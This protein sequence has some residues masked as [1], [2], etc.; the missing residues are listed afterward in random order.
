M[1]KTIDKGAVFY[2]NGTWNFIAKVV[3]HT[4]YTIE[5]EKRTGFSSIEEAEQ[6]Q[7]QENDRYKKHIARVKS[8]TNMRY[9]FFEYLDYWYQNIYLPNSDSSIKICYSWT[10]YKIIFPKARRDVLIGM[11][12]SDYLNEILDSCK[13][14]CESAGPMINKLFSVAL[15]D[16]MDDDYL[17]HNPLTDMKKYYWN[18]PKMVIYSKDQIRTL[19]QAAYEY[20]SI[21]LE[22]LLALFAGLRKGEIA[23]L[24]YSDFDPEKQTVRIERQITR[25]YQVVVKNNLSYK[26]LSSEQSIKPPKSLC[27][28]RTLRVHKIIFDE[29]E[30]RKKENMQLFEKLGVENPEWKEYISIG[31]KGSIKCENTCNAALERICVRNSLP[32][33]SMHD[34][35]HIFATILI[36]QG[37]SLDEISKVMGHKSPSTTFEV[38]CGII[39]AKESISAL[40]DSSFDPVHAASTSIK[41]GGLH[42]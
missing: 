17:S 30:I 21:Y 37:M 27:S 2:E 10:I 20:H 15:K 33:I 13:N 31:S 4:T 16:A 22:I 6:A 8:L 25:D 9:T 23:G 39:A 7:K 14:Y 29:L 18:G 36:E 24:K 28:Y 11:V 3:N 34:L 42:E 41:G 12:T 1:E 26:I 19:L 32:R 40:V 35:R 5:Y 38:Y